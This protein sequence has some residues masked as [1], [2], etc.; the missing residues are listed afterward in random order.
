[1]ADDGWGPP[2]A[3]GDAWG[4][5]VGSAPPPPPE[6][7][8]DDS[9][10]AMNQAHAADGWGPPVSQ[11]SPASQDEPMPGPLSAL[12]QGVQAGLGETKESAQAVQ[13]QTPVAPAPESSPAAGPLQWS[14]LASPYA[15][16]LP[17]VAYS[18]GKGSPTLAAGVAGGLAGSV[19]GPEGTLAGGALGSAAG[20]AFQAVGPAFSQELRK[21]PNDPDGAWN[22]A[23]EQA[24]VSGAFS[25][26]GWALFPA[27]FFQGPLKNLAF[28]AFGVQ[29]GVG[30][31][32]QAA[33]N[34]LQ[35]KPATQD[36]GQAYAAGAAETAV[37]MLGHA[38]LHA[39]APGAPDVTATPSQTEARPGQA[40]LPERPIDFA[41]PVPGA[42]PDPATLPQGTFNRALD[43]SVNAWKKTFQP[44]Q[45]SD[46]ALQANSEFRDYNARA[47]QRVDALSNHMDEMHGA[48]EKLA[49]DPQQAIDFMKAH[50]GE[51]NVPVA[52]ELQQ[53]S[54]EFKQLLNMA[55]A[56]DKN[57][58]AKYGFV[59]DYLPRMY[60]DPEAAKNFFQGKYMNMGSPAFQKARTLDFL[61]DG[62]DMGLQL[63]TN[64]VADLVTDRLKGSALLQE[65]VRLMQRLNQMGAAGKI[66]SDGDRSSAVGNGWNLVKDP[67]GQEWAIHP[68]LKQTWDN[69]LAADQGMWNDPSIAGNIFRTWMK[70]KNTYVPIKLAVSMFHPLHV[71]HINMNEGLV[72]GW[73]KLTRAGDPLGALGAVA[74]GFYGQLANAIPYLPTEAKAAREA[75][76]TPEWKQTP[77]QQ[78][79]VRM[80]TEG[81]FSPQLS[82]ELRAYNS[83]GFRDALINQ[84]WLRAIPYAARESISMLQKPIFE[85]W[86]PSLKTAAYLDEARDLFQ[87]RPDLIDDDV[88]RKAALSTI[89]KSIDN[90][91]GEMFYRNLH[92]NKTLKDIGIG[93]FLSLGWNLGFLRE[94]GGGALEPFMRDAMSESPTRRAIN[95]AKSK[96]AFAL[97]YMTS[98]MI[99]NSLITSMV[100]GVNYKDMD[101]MDYILPRIGG[102]NPDGSPRRVSNMF[103]TREIPMAEKHIE[104][105][106]SIPKGLGAM[107]WNKMMFEPFQEMYNNRDYYGYNIWDDQAPWYKQWGQLIK[108][109]GSDQ[110]NPIT[111]SGAKRALQATGKWND[112]DPIGNFKKIFTE[113]E[114]QAA[115]LGFGPAPT[116]ASKTATLNRLT[117]LFSRYVSPEERP[118]QDREVMEQRR[119]ARNSLAL[120]KKNND[121]AGA[122]AATRQLYNLG[123]STG[124]MKRNQPGTQDINMFARLP[125]TIQGQFLKGLNKTDFRRY[126]PRASKQT[127]ADPEIA[128]M[129]SQYFRQ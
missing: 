113:P 108:Y 71:G 128:A 98:A 99:L 125:T 118:Q 40:P 84:Q 32:E 6:P 54:T 41:V 106:Q 15:S 66:N 126:F 102:T 79:V 94:F 64:N 115:L 81:G 111:I 7:K 13:G 28:Q 101:F 17:K 46:L 56:A 38:A 117:Y 29:P 49:T 33:Q 19:V 47:A 93:S 83:R 14:D 67:T 35:G 5:V 53:Y 55:Y 24:S 21:T 37:P 70:T 48:F 82:E 120:A 34:V 2:V 74:K 87:R 1:M 18:L 90:R 10:V 27:R 59:Q 72:R 107:L 88:N 20:A 31:A 22:R 116:Y 73:N 36:L 60:T 23:L 110:F 68:D 39:I 45:V 9:S 69:T 92:W 109:I 44:E 121:A 4:P 127:R 42:A 57:A 30:V 89:A 65:K 11:P 78:E 100:G 25:G 58:G 97:S 96:T 76:L 61:Q 105:Q 122:V 52:P 43:K 75:W 50:T 119:D 124:S 104:E 12:E 3:S 77:E 16:L 123:V 51:S 114:G 95:D 86:I 63:K 26:A 80:M 91:Y 129:A 8:P 112:D 103:Y 62:L 85:H